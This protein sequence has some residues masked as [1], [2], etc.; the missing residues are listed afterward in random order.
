MKHDS[1]LAPQTRT[2]ARTID[3]ALFAATAVFPV[4]SALLLI[5][6]MLF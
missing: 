4:A 5:D 6:L 3:A 2:I 1:R